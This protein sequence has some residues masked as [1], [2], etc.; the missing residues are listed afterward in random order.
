MASVLIEADLVS[1]FLVEGDL[2]SEFLVVIFF[3]IYK[4]VEFVFF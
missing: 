1:E 2:V 4:K 3:S